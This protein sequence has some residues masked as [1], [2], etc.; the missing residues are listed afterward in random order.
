MAALGVRRDAILLK[1]NGIARIVKIRGANWPYLTLALGLSA[2]C[3]PSIRAQSPNVTPIR[4]AMDYQ[5][6]KPVPG[7]VGAFVTVEGVLTDG[8]IPVGGKSALVDIQDPSG[9]ITVYGSSAALLSSKIKPGDELLVTGKVQVYEGQPEIALAN[10]KDLGPGQIPDV[11]D[12]LAGDVAGTK[13]LGELVRVEGKIRLG[14]DG[15]GRPE[16][17]VRDRTGDI[18][19]YAGGLFRGAP[20]ISE[21]VARGGTATIVGVVNYYQSNDKPVQL[22]YRLIPRNTADVVIHPTPD[23]GTIALAAGLAFL[24]FGSIYLAV[25]RRWAEKRAKV[26]DMIVQSLK[27]SETALRQSE[28]RYRNLFDRNLAGLFHTTLDG[29]IV[30]CNE[31]FAR[32]FGYT[33]RE[34]VLELP[35]GAE[36]FYFDLSQREKMIQNLQGSRVLS[37]FE[38]RLRRK[39]GS[40][41]WVLENASL[42]EQE[43]NPGLLIEGTVVDITERKHLEEQLHQTQKMEAIGKLAGGVAHDLNNLLTVISGNTELMLGQE[44]SRSPSNK[45]ARQIQK[46]AEQA[47]DLVRQLL[48]FSR[49]QVLQ[50]K[51]LDLNTV[52]AETAGMLPRLLRED[53]EVVLVRGNSLGRVKADQNQ[54]SRI[55][56]NLAANARD[57]MP[58]GG[59][60]TIET[61]TAEFD[62]EYARRHPD[63]Q[64]GRY[65]V[66]SV[67]DTG[68]GMDAETKAHIFEPF[69]TT[70]EP[71]KGTG[72]GLATVYGV[73]K[74]SGG[75]VGVDSEPGRG[76]TMKIYLPRIE[77]AAQ[78]D[79]PAISRR[80]AARGSETILLVDDQEAIRELAQTYLEGLGY[81]VL[82][83]G[84]GMEAME[85]ARRQAGEIHLL[86]TD[87]VMPKLSGRQLAERLTPLRPEMRVIYMS[88]YMED[89]AGENEG[90]R[91]NEMHLHKPFSMDRLASAVRE[92]LN[93]EACATVAAD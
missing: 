55:L 60:L 10:V 80:P 16:I 53:I 7:H 41:I 49:M 29:R 33:S 44:T 11:R 82:V 62:E 79:E 75:W 23:Y 36:A 85:V 24:I 28:Q 91:R 84:D 8:P 35:R 89:V 52:I 81:H 88:G 37:S 78:T 48:A 43:D 69:F 47:A 38:T 68:V 39:D 14:K 9:G 58:N 73:V 21:E 74:Q 77:E 12:V 13:Y 31:S 25:R 42:L 90:S 3:G 87:V 46:A 18:P 61:S 76:T 67:T 2:I 4:E 20:E 63:V 40:A 86:L 83:A 17:I 1:I 30:N 56:F 65:V 57:A 27:Y 6:D 66:L 34:E 59:T 93:A 92:A 5:Q 64:R 71:G 19:A 70:K 32:M 51:V 15:A 26:M 45:N 72:L 54:V 22:S 50:P